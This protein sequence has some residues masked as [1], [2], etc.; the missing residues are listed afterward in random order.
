VLEHGG[1]PR[2][3]RAAGGWPLTAGR[4]RQ[5][6]QF[7]QAQRGRFLGQHRHTGPQAGERLLIVERR[8]RAQVHQVGLRL[9]QQARQVGGLLADPVLGAEVRQPRR[10]DVG[11]AGDLRLASQGAQGSH[12]DT[13]DVPGAHDRDPRRSHPLRPCSRHPRTRCG[14]Q[15]SPATVCAAA[16]A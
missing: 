4:L 3:A 15:P 16:A 2:P 5:H 7:P 1:E 13:G 12:V 9:P 10:V 11:A 14:Q 6:V 8:R